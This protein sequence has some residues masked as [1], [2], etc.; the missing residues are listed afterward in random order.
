MASVDSHQSGDAGPEPILSSNEGPAEPSLP[1]AALAN[2]DSP[3]KTPPP[4]TD[5]YG[6]LGGKQFTDPEGERQLSH[7]KVRRRETKWLEM[8]INWDKWM[9]KKFKKVKERC[10]KGIPP[11]LRARA[12]QHLCGSFFAMEQN[13]GVFDDYLKLPGDP[14]CIDDIQKDLDRQFPLH[15][16][17]L[18]K[19]G[20]GQEALFDVL[21]AYSIHR[22]VDG[23]CQAQAPIAAILLMHMPAEQAFWCLVAICDK[24]IIEYFAPGLEAVQLD[25]DILLGLLKKTSPAIHKHMRKQNI[26]PIMFMTEWFMCVYTRS[27]PWTTVLRIW[28]QFLCEGL[29]VVF[30]VGLVLVRFA[31]EGPD[32][33]A[34]CPSFYETLEKLRMRT[35]PS[36]LQDE[37]FL[38][39]ETLRL[40]INERDM[41]KEHQKQ[42]VRRKAAKEEREREKEHSRMGVGGEAGGGKKGKSGRKS[43]LK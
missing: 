12:W 23:Y 19:G 8:F 39:A 15:E 27:L 30:R 3:S 28:D 35:L 10:R 36:A 17:F 6:F 31:L 41:M 2:G 5:R 43:K 40:N 26:E 14:R 16:M 24:Y 42:L 1:Q 29:K 11:S 4:A 18:S 13:R 20:V 21:K 22:P 32:A 7:E 9:S 25:G 38:L 37:E 33:L 34:A